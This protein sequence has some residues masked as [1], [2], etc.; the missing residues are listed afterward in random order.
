LMEAMKGDEKVMR[1]LEV[2]GWRELGVVTSPRRGVSELARVDGWQS[3]HQSRWGQE[4]ER[5]ERRA[6]TPR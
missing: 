5:R 1:M 2:S 3:R 4:R 6:R